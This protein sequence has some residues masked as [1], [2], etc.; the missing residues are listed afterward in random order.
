[1]IRTLLLGLAVA[2]TLPLASAFAQE[3]PAPTVA[4]NAA[5]RELHAFFDA[6]WE[7]GLR[8]SP[9]TASYHGDPRYNDRW[10]DLS[11]RRD[12]RAR[13]RR[14][15]RAGQAEGRSTARSSAA[16]GPAQ[17]RRLPVADRAARV[18]R[19]KFQRIPAADRAS[20]RHRRTPTAITEVLPFA[21][22]KDYRD[23][24]AAHAR[25]CPEQ[26]DHTIA[27][28][29]EGMK[30]GNVPPKVL[31]QRVPAQIA[32]QLVEDPTKSP[33]YKPFAKFTRRRAAG[34]ACVAL[35][36]EAQAT[37][38]AEAMVPA[39]RK[40]AGVL[41]RPSTCRRPRDSIAAADLPDGK[42]Y[43]DFLAR[44]YTTTDLGADADP[45][46]RPEGSRAHP[47]RDGEDQ[48][49]G[50]VQGHAGASSSTTCAPI[51]SSS[52]RRRRSCWRPT[53]RSP[54]ASIRN[55]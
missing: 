17:L 25:R 16:D 51:R 52:T 3:T 18:E 40:L 4:A 9:E 46:H 13:G 32:A 43:Y 53:G 41:Q 19:Q 42:A 14:S 15:R 5:S 23:W 22:A 35:Q 10:T 1:M 49:R 55:W 6:E 21:T 48:G 28:M 34:R 31:M 30:A 44:Y 20:G 24:L 29:R 36:A 7:R 37:I 33:F 39:Y 27:L 2:A 47:R 54:S 38:V 45:R 26:V 12:H 8:E 11:L 50:R